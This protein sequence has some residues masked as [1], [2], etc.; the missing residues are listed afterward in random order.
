MLA[1][2]MDCH[3]ESLKQKEANVALPMLRGRKSLRRV[4]PV[5]K[6]AALLKLRRLKVNVQ[7][8]VARKMAG[9]LVPFHS[10][11]HWDLTKCW[12][13]MQRLR[14][15]FDGIRAF[16]VAWDESNHGNSPI[17]LFVAYSWEKNLAGHLPQQVMAPVVMA[18]LDDT[19][20]EIAQE[21]RCKRLA[22]FSAMRSLENA[23]QQMGWSLQQLKPPPGVLRPLAANEVRVKMDGQWMV[24]NVQSGA[25]QWLLDPNA[26]LSAIKY[27]SL[28]MDQGAQE[29][30]PH[31][32]Q[33]LPC[34]SWC[35]QLM[36]AIIVAGMT[37][38][39]PSRGQMGSHTYPSY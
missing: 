6:K 11:Q 17:C 5:N 7:S 4:D 13:Y 29:W 16:S 27:L 36:T 24:V 14:Q 28:S 32:I 21:N 39:W 15:S 2:A 34:S 22:S 38:S 31:T 20:L 23:L 37:A 10:T 25:S 9:D 18:D 8:R 26:D 3:M 1:Q 19:L 33:W 35:M 12:L 30:Q